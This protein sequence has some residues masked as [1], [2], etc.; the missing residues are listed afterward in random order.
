M[1]KQQ[2]SKSKADD[3]SLIQ[4]LEKAFTISTAFETRSSDWSSLQVRFHTS[5]QATIL[6]L[7][8]VQGV[9]DRVHHLYHVNLALR[10]QLENTSDKHTRSD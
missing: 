2:K 7:H 4:W 9:A 10:E 1:Y 8:G 6:L 3:E 5:L